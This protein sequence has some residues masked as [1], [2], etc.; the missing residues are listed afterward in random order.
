MKKL[1]RLALG[2]AVSCIVFLILLQGKPRFTNAARPPRGISDP[3]VALQVARNIGE[4]DDIL[5]DE[6]SADREVMRFKQYL[7]FGFIAAYT[8]LF[9]VLALLLSREGRFASVAG[10]ATAVCALGTAAFDVLEDIAILRILDV[11]LR[12]TTGAMINSIRSASGAK[13]GLAALTLAF[14]S[15]LL[16]KGQGWLRRTNGVLVGVS[17]GMVVYGFRDNRFFIFQGYPAFVALI[18]IAIMFFPGRQPS[19]EN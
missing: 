1:P 5:G 13:W 2:L 16:V 19:L 9:C 10:A 11:P 14:L 12:V 15:A 18:G 7:D 3:V 17:A 4:V 6:P 8:G